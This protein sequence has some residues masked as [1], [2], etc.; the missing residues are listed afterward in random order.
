MAQAAVD[1]KPET[2]VSLNNGVITISNLAVKMVGRK[3]HPILADRAEATPAL[4]N[5][6]F[7]GNDNGLWDWELKVNRPF[8]VREND[9]Y[10]WEPLRT[11]IIFTIS[12]HLNLSD[13][14]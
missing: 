9:E 3:P 10:E 11:N 7:N 13:L 2:K 14:I 5:A 1:E 8:L 6:H 4:N 12:F